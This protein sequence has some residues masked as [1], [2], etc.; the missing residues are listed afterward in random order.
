MKWIL[1]I[2]LTISLLLPI[3]AQQGVNA[4]VKRHIVV[5]VDVAYTDYTCKSFIADE[6]TMDCIF[7]LL[8]ENGFCS[9]DYLSFVSYSLNLTNPDFATFVSIAN[10]TFGKPI[11][12]RQY[13]DASAARQA[14][15]SNWYDITIGHHFE[16]IRDGHAGS[17]QSLVKQ[18]VLKMLKS[19]QPKELCDETLLLIITDEVVN[20]V[21]NNYVNEYANVSFYNI[22]A[23]DKNKIAVFDF[24]KECDANFQFVRTKIKNVAGLALDGQV[25]IFTDDLRFE[26]KSNLKVVPYIVLPVVRPA[27]QSITDIPSPL[28]IKIIKDGY[29]LDLDVNV[30]SDKFAIN[31]MDLILA[32]GRHGIDIRDGELLIKR[33][34]LSDGDSIALEMDVRY[35]DGIYNAISMSPKVMIYKRGLTLQTKFKLQQDTKILGMVPLYDSLWWFFP[36]DIQMAVMTWN[37]IIIL[38]FIML[39]CYIAFRIFQSITRYVPKNKDISLVKIQK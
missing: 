16:Y 2:L 28:P 36:N 13:K 1:I 23:F 19:N 27:I 35:L 12:W 5:A 20:G 7:R 6:N 24:A 22:S 9:N 39:V 17:M 3:N 32:D 26:Q 10:D 21:D 15:K 33:D 38:I 25:G 11:R 8:N 14:M 34:Q 18:Y 37:I 29:K 30:L 4:A 31:S